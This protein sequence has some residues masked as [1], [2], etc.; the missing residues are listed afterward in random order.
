MLRSLLPLMF[1]IN[2]L[3]STIIAS[4]FPNTSPDWSISGG[5]VVGLL[6]NGLK[7]QAASQ[8]CL[9]RPTVLTR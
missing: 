2:S 4:Y 1:L 7:K 8:D 9:C 6:R 5:T 3:L